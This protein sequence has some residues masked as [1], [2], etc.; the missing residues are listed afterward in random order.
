MVE[1]ER[2]REFRAIKPQLYFEYLSS[3]R[4]SVYT[5]YNYRFVC[6]KNTAQEVCME[7]IA[8]PSYGC[9]PVFFQRNTNIPQMEEGIYTDFYIRYPVKLHTK[10]VDSALLKSN[11]KQFMA[12]MNKK[13]EMPGVSFY[14]YFKDEEGKAYKKLVVLDM[15]KV[16]NRSVEETIDHP[17]STKYRANL[18]D[19]EYTFASKMKPDLEFSLTNDGH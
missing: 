13:F 9:Y 14:L 16:T 15:E 3:G 19:N 17:H 2:E 10:D 6:K 11:P 4:D 8:M 5:Y 1:L 7:V 18:L 12:E